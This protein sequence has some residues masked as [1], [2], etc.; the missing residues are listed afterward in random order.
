MTSTPNSNHQKNQGNAGQSSGYQKTG[1]ASALL[2]DSG[3]DSGSGDLNAGFA[4]FLDVVVNLF[5]LAGI[6]IGAFE[7]PEE[8]VFSR[9]IP[10]SIV[11]IVVGNIILVA[12][13]RRVARETGQTGLTAIPS[14]LDL[15]TVFGMSFFV[16]GPI[17]SLYRGEIG[18]LAAGELAWGAGMAAA[19]WMAFTKFVLSFASRIVERQIPP[20]ALIGAMGG[21]A[22]VWLGAEAMLGLFVLPEVGLVAF[23]IMAFSLIA[24]HQLPFRFPGAIAAIV[25]ATLV[26]YFLA[27]TG[28]GG[29][30]LVPDIPGL[31]PVLPMPSL[32][33]FSHIFG[34]ITAYLGL[35][36][37]FALLIA[38]SSINVVAG[39][40]VVGDHY[41]P[42]TVIR[43]DSFATS[44]SALFGGVVQT[45]PYFGHPTYKRMGAKTR[46]SLVT[47]GIVAAGGFGGVIAFA[48]VLI[49][50]PILK[51]IL[52]VVAADILRLSF[53]VGEVR[54]APALL[55]AFIPAILNYA[56]TKVSDLYGRLGTEIQ[57]SLGVDFLNQYMLLGVMARGYILTSLIWGTMIVWIIDRRFIR[58]GGAALLAA[59]MTAFGIIHSILPSSGLYVPWDLPD[60]GGREAL[61]I[62][63]MLAY[64]I[65]AILIGA[66]ALMKPLQNSANKS[67]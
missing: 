2:P 39:A 53:S 14:G 21:I 34:E 24:G 61:A 8:I 16:L 47:A 31:I 57:T 7:F 56:Y 15:P 27:F 67:P 26:Y 28:S 11:G 55:L 40:R 13:T 58:A 32:L 52:I 19:L 42:A 59:T 17:Y 18:D 43:L 33:G 25:I 36:I 23:A 41:D 66:G 3:A 62:R 50:E 29:G 48:S 4:F 30:Y 38:A 1:V 60:M 65:M 20:I 37:P 46:Y 64:I 44:I 63:I 10:G 9:I 45:T 5:V 54:H 22:L 12:Y 6:L 35:V 51:P 49:P